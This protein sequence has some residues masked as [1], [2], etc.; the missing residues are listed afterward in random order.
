MEVMHHDYELGR[1]HYLDNA[2]TVFPKPKE[3]LEGMLRAYQNYGVN[4]GRS[5]YDLCLI[6]GDIVQSTR[7]KLTRFFRGD[8][9]ERLC[10]TYNASDSLNLLILGMVHEGDHV[11][12]TCLEHN[13][14]IRPLN[15]L[16]KNGTI[17]VEYVPCGS[18]CVID[19]QEIVK[20]VRRNTRLVVVNHGSNVVGAI[21]P[22]AE[23]GKICREREIRFVVDTAQ[24]A[25][26]VPIDIEE[27]YIDALAFTGHKSLL[28]PTGI[29]GVYVAKGV[30]VD[31]TRFGGT[32]VKSAYPYHLEEYPYRLEIGTVNILGIAG[33]GLAQDYL[34]SRGIENIY[35]HEMELFSRLQEGIQNI[36]RIQIHGTTSLQNR[37]P[38][39]SLTVDGL[40]PSDV[41]TFLDVDHNVACRTGLQCAPLIH[42]QMGTSPRGT[43]RLSVGPS[44]TVDDVNAALDAIQD[45]ASHTVASIA[46]A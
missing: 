3:I 21:Q 23:I 38:V 44:N 32:G 13:S 40:D 34:V 31:H 4:P 5:G 20:K 9:P 29:G 35:Q 14:V 33:L 45:I 46:Q 22:V 16:Q 30:V 25:G 6:G 37:L 39:L 26:V 36:S 41:G 10:F 7:E 27:M 1:I 19:P 28:G 11:I 2:A 12:S 43:V 18:D 17:E 8:S 24:T 42:D 15:C